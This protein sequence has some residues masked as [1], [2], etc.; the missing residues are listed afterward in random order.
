MAGFASY[1]DI[2]AEITQNGKYKAIPFYKTSS[3]PEAAG[4]WHSLWKAAGNPGA[5]S[6]PAG[7]PGAAYSSAGMSLQ[8]EASDFKH[9]LSLGATATQNTLLMLYDRLVGVGAVS[10]NST[11][12]KT[13]NSAALTRY[14]GGEGV[15]AWL[16]VTTVTSSTA[17][18][19]MNSYTNQAGT[20]GRAGTSVAFPAATTNVD[21]L[22]QLPLQ[23]GDKG[24]RA[25]ST[26]NVSVSGGGS[27]AV[28][29]ILIRPLAFLPIQANIYNERDFILQVASLPRLFDGASLALAYLAAS[30]TAPTFYGQIQT[31]WG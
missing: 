24:V 30:T 5:E 15:Q 2:I 13:I 28:S 20:T 18:V 31:A 29:L 6:D 11:G 8:D 4:T 3:S 26:I 25:V 14:T 22:V 12:D 16:E 10:I 17:T 21:T 23:A 1:D 19:S 27:A 7:T 9:L